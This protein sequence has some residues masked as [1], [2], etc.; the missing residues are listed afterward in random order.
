MESPG[1]PSKLRWQTPLSRTTGG[2]S[3]RFCHANEACRSSAGPHGELTRSAIPE[4]SSSA[5]RRHWPTCHRL[6]RIGT[7]ALEGRLGESPLF[8]CLFGAGLFGTEPNSQNSLTVL[9]SRRRLCNRDVPRLYCRPH[10]PGQGFDGRLWPI[11]MVK[12]VARR[13]DTLLGLCP[14]FRDERITHMLGGLGQ[15]IPVV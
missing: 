8:F 10:R 12:S 5:P 13:A 7:R 6:A 4:F 15:R 1:Y 9:E 3:L 14:E 2:G 11:R